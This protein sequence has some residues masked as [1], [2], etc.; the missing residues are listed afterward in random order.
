MLG[1]LADSQF[2]GGCGHMAHLV[3]VYFPVSYNQPHYAQTM[4]YTIVIIFIVLVI[5]TIYWI[6]YAR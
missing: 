6:F 1:T 4:N 2:L 5:A 3:V